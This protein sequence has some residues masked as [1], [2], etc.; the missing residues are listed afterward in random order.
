[1]PCVDSVDALT[2]GLFA[3]FLCKFLCNAVNT[4]N[5]RYNPHLVAYTHITVL[6]NISFECAVLAKNVQFLV[7]RIVCIFE[8]A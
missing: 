6:A 2:L 5:G 7:D 8:F 1:M 3:K 4:A